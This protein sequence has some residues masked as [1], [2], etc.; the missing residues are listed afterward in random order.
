MELTEG[1]L[2]DVN[3]RLLSGAV[4]FAV[5]IILSYE[6]YYLMIAICKIRSLF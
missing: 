2:N 3:R 4:D 5:A 6:F 1:E